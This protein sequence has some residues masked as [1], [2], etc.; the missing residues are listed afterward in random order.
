MATGVIGNRMTPDVAKDMRKELRF[1][2]KFGNPF[3][4]HF[5]KAMKLI[6]FKPVGVTWDWSD[7]R[8]PNK[9]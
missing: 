8:P 4:K 9:R 5:Q 3:F 2:D 1:G 6:S 7:T